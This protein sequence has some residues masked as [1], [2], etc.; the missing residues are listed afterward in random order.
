MTSPQWL[1]R[2]ARVGGFDVPNW[3]GLAAAAVP[4]PVVAAALAQQ[5]SAARLGLGLAVVLL[6][7]VVVVRP[8]LP[9]WLADLAAAACAV[10]LVGANS[11]SAAL[12]LLFYLS[13]RAGLLG[14]LWQGA[15]VLA[16]C[17]GWL[18]AH[19]VIDALRGVPTGW[20]LSALGAVMSWGIGCVLRRQLHTM[21]ALKSAQLALARR[22]AGEERQRIAR[23]VHDLVG[24][25]LSVTML[26]LTGARLA[27]DHDVESA[28]RALL[29]AERL[30]RESMAE[31]RR[32]VGLL[33]E[34]GDAS[35]KSAPLPAATDIAGLVERCRAGGMDV[36]LDSEGD[37]ARPSAE[38]GLGA[39]RIIQESLS[40]AARHA[41]G[42]RTEVRVSF[43]PAAVSI[44][45]HSRACAPS[46]SDGAGRGILGMTERAALLGGALSAG[47][48]ED[49]WLVR[50]VLPNVAGAGLPL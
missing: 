45:V 22:A 19:A 44:D 40:N 15:T 41:P 5:W 34:G 2:R 10:A 43:G 37:P 48:T 11:A 39:Y 7:A 38:V 23:E 28:R 18:V 6:G 8:A 17:F 12:V 20:Y 29:E 36:A 14:S 16:L 13:G 32:T 50:A 3:L 27:L 47:P 1:R 21:A 25:S 26:H 35:T 9:C 46:P 49:G 30:A 31:I 4:V 42:A 24:H 33:A